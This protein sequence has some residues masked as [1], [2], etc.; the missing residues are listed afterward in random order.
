[1]QK[2]ERQRD[3]VIVGSAGR[4]GAR[5]SER[6]IKVGGR[7]GASKSGERTGFHQLQDYSELALW[8]FY[9]VIVGF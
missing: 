5:L 3:G 4:E 9:T 2:A 6:Q 7:H 8:C 1:M